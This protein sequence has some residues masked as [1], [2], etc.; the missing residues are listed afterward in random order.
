MHQSMLASKKNLLTI[1]DTWIHL[2]DLE[3][4]LI[5]Q[6]TDCIQPSDWRLA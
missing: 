6:F 5:D 4:N 3:K 1:I 2:F